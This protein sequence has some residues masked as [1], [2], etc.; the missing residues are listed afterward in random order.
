MVVINELMS[1]QIML[2]CERIGNCIERLGWYIV[3]KDEYRMI[4]GK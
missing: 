3:W 1:R 2:T 4:A